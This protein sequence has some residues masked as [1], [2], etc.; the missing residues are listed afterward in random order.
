MHNLGAQ[1]WTTVS[2][3]FARS[4]LFLAREQRLLLPAFYRLCTKVACV[5]R[6]WNTYPSQCFNGPCPCLE[7]QGCSHR[8]LSSSVGFDIPAGCSRRVL[9]ICQRATLF[10]WHHRR[11]R[12]LVVTT[13]AASH[14]AP[15]TRASR[16][17]PT[18][19]PA[20][21]QFHAEEPA[22]HTHAPRS[23]R[24]IYVIA[25]ATP[26][27]SSFPGPH[28]RNCCLC[29]RLPPIPAPRR[30]VAPRCLLSRRHG[31]PLQH[32]YEFAGARQ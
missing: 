19:P 27:G 30:R 3:L 8:P 15:T 20:A 4:V 22:A 16:R 28:A 9:V 31:S 24:C 21:C 7:C 10:D 17:L 12:P 26:A 18:H 32:H 29:R 5:V 1:Q 6:A 23:T 2:K 13:E 25:T 14:T 11:S